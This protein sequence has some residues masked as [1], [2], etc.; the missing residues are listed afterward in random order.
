MSQWRRRLENESTVSRRPDRNSEPVW[1][2][3]P[4]VPGGGPV[5]KQG[6]CLETTVLAERAPALQVDRTVGFLAP[7][8]LDRRSQPGSA[9]SN[10]V[11]RLTVA[12]AMHRPWTPQAIGYT[13]FVP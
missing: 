10:T 13:V 9:L 5:Q 8:L 1:V 4:P 7:V 6:R 11:D 3:H 12:T 2:Q